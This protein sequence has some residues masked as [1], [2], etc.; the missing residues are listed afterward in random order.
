MLQ[1]VTG[2]CYVL[3]SYVE[4][5]APNVTVFGNRVIREVIKVNWGHKGDHNLTGLVSL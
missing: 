5:L 2:Q 1:V 4:A 3:T